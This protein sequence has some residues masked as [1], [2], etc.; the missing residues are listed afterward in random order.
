MNKLVR[1][2]LGSAALVASL[3][4]NAT[5]DTYGELLSGT[6]QPNTTFASMTY[7]SIGNVYSFTL[8]AFDL[9]AIFTDGSFIGS[10]AVD[11]EYQPIISNVVGD[12]VVSV[13]NGGGPTGVF[14]FRFDLTGSQQDRLTANE[15]VSWDATFSQPVTLTSDS[16]ALHVQGLTTEQGGSGWYTATPVPEP[17]TYAMMLAGLGM[18]GFTAR[19]KTKNKL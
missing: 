6:Y 15:T 4:A 8:S 19:R 11:S 7:T 14:D 9:D 16:F 13:D 1:N 2:M 12:T 17:E 10:V 5:V 18:L 3:S